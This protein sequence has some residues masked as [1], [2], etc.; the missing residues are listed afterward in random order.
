MSVL[1]YMVYDQ[2]VNK[3]RVFAKRA[4]AVHQADKT[5]QKLN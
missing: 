2:S 4:S 5:L 3:R 1:L